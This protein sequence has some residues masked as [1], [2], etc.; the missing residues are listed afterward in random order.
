VAETRQPLTIPP[1]SQALGYSRLIEAEALAVLPPRSL[2]FLATQGGR[3]EIQTDG[4]RSTVYPAHYDPGPSI[5]DH[6]EFA[7]KHEG[8]NLEVLAAF[9]A[10]VDRAA[11]TA[12]IRSRPTGQYSRRAWFLFEW[13][14]DQRLD[15]EDLK[16]V[17]Y[18]PLVDPERFFTGL[19]NRSSRHAIDENLLGTRQFSPMVEKT[20]ALRRSQGDRLDEEARR[21]VAGYD[22]DT[23][24]R[25]VSFLYTKE[26]RSTWELER[27]KP[28]PQRGQRFILALRHAAGLDRLSE[29][30]F[31]K[32]QNIVV[33]AAY[34]D[35]GYRDSQNYVGSGYLGR[36]VVEF[37][38]PKPE[39][40]RSMMAGLIASVDRMR[41]S[42]IDPVVAAAVAGFGFVLVHPF[43]DGNGRLH[44]W[45]IHHVLSRAGFTPP[46]MIFPIS[47]VMLTRRTEYDDTLER[48]SR[49]LGAL[50]D[51]ELGDDGSLTV[52]GD[53][54]R[55]YRYFDCTAMAESLYRWTAET[56]RK[57]LK[58]E[59]DFLVRFRAARA[60]MDEVLDMPD[61][62]GSLFVK[63]VVENAG[64]LSK[65]KRARFG[66]L[67]DDQVVRL[68]EIV[69][70]NFFGEG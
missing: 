16:S 28:N 11:L 64:H 49:P 6:L 23:V 17:P 37:V 5:F 41:A 56:V 24:K 10:K 39:D 62:E 30:E 52:H 3:R 21:L 31:V 59:L 7:L 63:L 65:A 66:E 27:E 57:E 29:A 25:A 60:E 33:D 58:T 42:E 43:R 12:Y 70:R 35:H 47:A 34:A 44:R 22:E 54:A 9:F 8:I 69:R 67:S 14:T 18:V 26:T 15:L 55:H 38:C 53:T 51:Y 13:L 20:E 36:G 50:I 32:L 1:R 61:R 46:G 2:A 40:V 48:F 45:L 19:P 68:E 4:R